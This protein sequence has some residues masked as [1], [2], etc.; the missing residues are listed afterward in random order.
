VLI[1][2]SGL[3]GTGKS[4]VAAALAARAGAV[5]L[6]IDD[7]E[8]ALLGSGVEECWTTG[9]AAYE[10]VR[11]A[12]EQNLALGHMVVVDAVNDSEPARDTWR[13]AALATGSPL[14]FVVLIP[15]NPK[16]HR[17]RLETRSRGLLHVAEPT[18]E[19]V[20]AR[21]A[22]YAPWVDEPFSVDAAQELE[23]VVEQVTRSLQRTSSCP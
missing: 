16:E 5:H 4:A 12:A 6:S 17:R 14:R 15:P 23:G 18:W 9:V 3:P 1:V 11:V 2:I 21:A 8:E 19:Q 10:V 22:A 7:F 13:R 20:K